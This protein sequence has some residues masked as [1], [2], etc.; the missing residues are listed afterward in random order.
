MKYVLPVHEFSFNKI[1]NGSR[2]V[3]VHLL[4]KKA[5]QIKIRDVLELHNSSTDEIINGEVLGIA[6][7]DTFNDLVDAITPQAL[8]YLDKKEVM[9][10]VERIFPKEARD[11][12]NCVAFY[13]RPIVEKVNARAIEQ[14]ER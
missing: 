8:G 5:Q 6:M 2:R 12:L 7:F 3:G 11:A 10:R 4:D 1:K 14:N 13:I 9:L